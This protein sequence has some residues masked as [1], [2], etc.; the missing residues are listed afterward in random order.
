[1]DKLTHP[2][3]CTL[4]NAWATMPEGLPYP[5]WAWLGWSKAQLEDWTV[6]NVIPEQVVR[7]TAFL[8]WGIPDGSD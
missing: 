7:P 1:M 3:I 2:E 6:N 8:V 5:L 4:I